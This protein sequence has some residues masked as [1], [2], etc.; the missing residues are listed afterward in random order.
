MEVT[1]YYPSKSWIETRAKQLDDAYSIRSLESKYSSLLSVLRKKDVGVNLEPIPGVEDNVDNLLYVRKIVNL[2]QESKQKLKRDWA[3]INALIDCDARN[4]SALILFLT[5]STG[6]KIMHELAKTKC[7]TM[8]SVWNKLGFHSKLKFNKNYNYY[9]SYYIDIPNEWRE[10]TKTKFLKFVSE[11]KLGPVEDKNN[12]K[13]SNSKTYYLLPNADLICWD[14]MSRHKGMPLLAAQKVDEENLMIFEGMDF[15]AQI[16]VFYGLKTAGVV[17]PGATKVPV[18]AGKK[19]ASIMSLAPLPKIG[20]TVCDRPYILAM[21]GAYAKTTNSAKG[22]S[23]AKGNEEVSDTDRLLKGMYQ[24]IFTVDDAIVRYLLSES[25]AK[26]TKYTLDCLYYRYKLILE[27]YLKLLNS[28]PM[29]SDGSEKGEW[30]KFDTVLDWL[31]YMEA[32]YTENVNWVSI[33]RSD[34]ISTQVDLS[35]PDLY[36]R[37][38]YPVIFGVM[39]LLAAMGLIDLAYNEDDEGAS[40]KFLRITNAGLWATDR[41]KKLKVETRKM[42]DGLHFD[43]DSLMITIR[44]TNSPNYVLLS[45][46]TEKVT[47]NRF[48]IT[49]A[50]ILKGCKTFAEMKVR[51]D[52][53][54]DYVLGGEESPKLSILIGRL[55]GRLNKVKITTDEEYI[56]MDVDPDDKNL[57]QLLSNTSIIRKNTLRVEGWKLLVK[58]SFY[59]T[60]LEKLRQGGYLT[61]ST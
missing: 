16:P 36:P 31:L 17:K 18:S 14:I 59:S 19:V 43:P 2:M 50:A 29:T 23:K 10:S 48:K 9:Y 7:L 44:D 37:I 34:N 24:R 8:Q 56:C 52:R 6:E 39:Q 32:I 27:L 41:I 49:E 26:P 1:L 40:I 12:T 58:K 30:V 38:K 60:L 61:E 47:P 5:D 21:T 11:T 22:K 45:D 33:D 51:I 15:I 46:L 4:L 20:Y 54:K 42:D 28:L 25:V 57:H 35:Y 3:R 55:Y 13:A 53:L